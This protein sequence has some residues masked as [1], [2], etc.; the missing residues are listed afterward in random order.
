M[1][2]F[3]DQINQQTFYAVLIASLVLGTALM[4]AW[5]YKEW[6]RM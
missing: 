6:S 3:V 4:C 1:F 2:A 5:L